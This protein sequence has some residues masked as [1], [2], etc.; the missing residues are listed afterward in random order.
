[1]VSLDSSMK[2]EKERL[3]HLMV[4]FEGVHE[5]R[6]KI[7]KTCLQQRQ[8]IENLK[9]FIRVNQQREFEELRAAR[10]S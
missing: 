7:N 9:Q 10:E 4:K 6:V 8:Y 5:A 2:H 3:N 1:M